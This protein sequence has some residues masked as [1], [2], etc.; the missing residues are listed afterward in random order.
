MLIFIFGLQVQTGV[1]ISITKDGI[2]AYIDKLIDYAVFNLQNFDFGNFDEKIDLGLTGFRVQ[3]DNIR[4]TDFMAYNYTFTLQPQYFDI[5]NA[6]IQGSLQYNIFQTSFPYLEFKGGSTGLMNLNVFAEVNFYLNESTKL[7]NFKL[8]S[9]ST[10]I[11]NIEL[12]LQDGYLNQLFTTFKYV[13]EDLITKAIFPVGY[14]ILG[15]IINGF[16][17]F[18]YLI[19]SGECTYSYQFNNFKVDSRYIV[20]QHQGFCNTAVDTF[21]LPDNYTSDQINYIISI[22]V[23]KSVFGEN[24]QISIRNGIVVRLNGLKSLCQVVLKS[25]VD[26]NDNTKLRGQVQLNCENKQIEM[27]FNKNAPLLY[28]VWFVQF[29]N[30]IYQPNYVILTGYF[31]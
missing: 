25:V 21:L 28:N 16:L 30:I 13:F 27:L 24:I 20:F 18:N 15:Q 29:G 6:V 12:Y 11:V 2:M 9:I 14:Q 22:D 3:I 10:Q 17:N 26:D 7:L 23:I 4:I 31:I 8:V 5:K 1:S 19:K